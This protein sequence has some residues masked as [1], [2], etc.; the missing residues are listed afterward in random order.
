VFKYREHR[1]K[2]QAMLGEL[3]ERSMDDN[4]S[5]PAD[6]LTLLS[7]VMEINEAKYMKRI[8]LVRTAITAIGFGAIIYLLNGGQF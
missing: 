6:I 8:A 5:I 2:I 4:K 1:K 3:S 7:V